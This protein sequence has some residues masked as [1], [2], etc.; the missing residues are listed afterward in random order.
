MKLVFA[1]TSSFAV[2]TLQALHQAGHEVALVVTQPDRPA[3]RGLQLKGS[4]VRTAALQLGLEVFQPER[5]KH[6]A[7]TERIKAVAPDLQVVVA[8]GQI[9]PLSLLNLPRLG[10]I[11]LHAS[12]LPR[13][14]GPAP[15]AAAILNGDLETGVTVMQM[16]VGVDTGPI[17]AQRRVAVAPDETAGSLEERLAEIGAELMVE[18]LERFTRGQVPPTP[19]PEDGAS[20]AP[21]LSSAD[22]KLT[23]EMPAV[24]IDRRVRALSQNPGCWIAL[25]AGEVKILRGH[26]GDGRDAADRDGLRIETSKGI[27]VIDE[28]Q[29]PG[30]RP[31]KA[32][33][34]ARGRR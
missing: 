15:V 16:D 14:R 18:T 8:Y 2:P 34:W 33:A 1:G 7:S 21:M 20:R 17:L 10:S 22:G 28:V 4:P 9:L 19:Q 6:A 23:L 32:A 30:G 3:G 13:Y 31:M 29:P 5:I 27:Y 12:L 26:L 25:P 24:E 11:N